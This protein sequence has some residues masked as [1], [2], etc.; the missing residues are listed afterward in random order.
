MTGSHPKSLLLTF[1]RGAL[2]A[3]FSQFE[4]RSDKYGVS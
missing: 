3:N 1:P 4:T 2:A